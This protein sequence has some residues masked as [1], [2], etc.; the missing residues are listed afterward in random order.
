MDI[1][2]S[3]NKSEVVYFVD[4]GF[5][6]R[7]LLALPKQQDEYSTGVNIADTVCSIISMIAR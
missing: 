1:K 2:K 6:A 5:E 3:P 7:T 4:E